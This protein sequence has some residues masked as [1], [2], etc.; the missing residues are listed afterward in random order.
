VTSGDLPVP[1]PKQVPQSR[2]HTKVSISNLSREG[3]S[4]PHLDSLSQ[5]FCHLP[6]KE[7][8]TTVTS[9]AGDT[10]R[11][12]D[13]LRIPSSI[14]RTWPWA[15]RAAM[16]ESNRKGVPATSSE[17]NMQAA[18]QPVSAA[19][20]LKAGRYELILQHHYHLPF[21]AVLAAN[22]GVG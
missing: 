3:D 9:F 12:T 18:I 19:V 11:F 10:I 21:A 22:K 7:A 4:I 13:P 14:L 20:G 15:D 6:S 16:G 1:P 5:C 17:S 8:R 2:L